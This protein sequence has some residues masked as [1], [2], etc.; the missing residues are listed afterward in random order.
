M[1]RGQSE[2]IGTVVLISVLLII[3]Y[4]AT[5]WLNTIYSVARSAVESIEKAKEYLDIAINSGVVTLVNK[6]SRDSLV[7]LMYIELKN[8]TLVV[9]EVNSIVKSG[10][11]V[12]IST[13]FSGLDIDRVC[14]ETVNN[15][16]F[17]SSSNQ[18]F[19]NALSM[20]RGFW[21]YERVPPRYYGNSSW[22]HLVYRVKRVVAPETY[23]YIY[24]VPEDSVAIATWE[25]EILHTFGKEKVYV[26]YRPSNPSEGMYISVLYNG[27]YNVYPSNLIDGEDNTL[28]VDIV[29]QAVYWLDICIDLGTTTKGWLYANLFYPGY[30]DPSTARTFIVVSNLSC[31]EINKENTTIW[32]QPHSSISASTRITGTWIV[33]G[34]SIRFYAYH[35][36]WEIYTVEFYPYNIT[37]TI[38]G[39]PSTK[40]SKPIST[41][42]T[43]FTLSNTY[44]QFLE[45]TMLP[46]IDTTQ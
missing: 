44:L 20:Y 1:I 16:V 41:I 9:R 6:G 37:R 23:F 45:L 42:V 25:E 46:R 19:N 31:A 11:N 7:D 4:V 33:N 34:R 21:S 18:G 28:G 15:N 24:A 26:Q 13:G 12:N 22:N 38:L 39:F 14:V 10:R 43:V 17:C 3:T 30:A 8:R 32:Y 27:D 36:G 29:S 2:Y 5:D 35:M 40:Y